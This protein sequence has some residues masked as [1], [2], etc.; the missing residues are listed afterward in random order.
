MSIALITGSA[1]LIG[2]EAATYFG[3]LGLDVVY[4]QAKRWRDPVSRPTVQ[5][6]AGSLDMHRARRSDRMI[7]DARVPEFVL[8]RDPLL[9]TP[10]ELGFEVEVCELLLRGRPA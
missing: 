8:A 10:F 1:G 3:K 6:F 7:Q 4:L 5:A 9:L 2:S